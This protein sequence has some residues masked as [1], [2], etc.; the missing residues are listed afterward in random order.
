MQEVLQRRGVDKTRTTPLHPQSDG[1]V[2]RHIN[3]VEKHPRNI[4]ALHQ[5]DWDVR[6]PIFLLVYRASTH[7]TTGFTPAS[8]VFG[9]EL[10]LPCNL[11][12]GHHLLLPSME[13]PKID[14]AANL[15]NHLHDTHNY[16]GKH[17]KLASDR[18]RTR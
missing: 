16:A 5:R 4:V 13:R 6:L 1:M 11:L 12:F 8:P 3:M 9:R 17:L 10:R 15:V 18:M 7:N 14:H 2:E